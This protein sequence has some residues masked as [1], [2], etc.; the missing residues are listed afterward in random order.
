MKTQEEIRSLI[1]A[2][3]T[4]T[5]EVNKAIE[6]GNSSDRMCVAMLLLP[7]LPAIDEFMKILKD[8][9][10]DAEEEKPSSE[11]P[12]DKIIH[13]IKPNGTIS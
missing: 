13:Q 1:E 12:L 2:F 8:E 11:D 7:L 4:V 3:R 10:K 5:K 9:V 6:S